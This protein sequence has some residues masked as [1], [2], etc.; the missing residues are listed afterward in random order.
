MIKKFDQIGQQLSDVVKLFDYAE[1][2]YR[3]PI[4]ECSSIN[5]KF[6]TRTRTNFLLLLQFM[7]DLK[8][9]KTKILRGFV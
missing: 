4:F 5:L 6:K 3:G 1:I 9:P 2:G 7:H 8:E